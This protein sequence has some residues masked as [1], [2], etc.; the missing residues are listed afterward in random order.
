MRRVLLIVLTAICLLLAGLIT[1]AVCAMIAEV[2]AE[3]PELNYKNTTITLTALNVIP[4][5][6]AM[7][8]VIR[9][10]GNCHKESTTTITRSRLFKSLKRAFCLQAAYSFVSVIF[11]GQLLD[12]GPAFVMLITLFVVFVSLMLSLLF[13]ILDEPCNG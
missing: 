5:M 3:T 8:S 13:H 10:A 6:L 2:Y 4:V 9:F 1:L 12:V 11:L 7:L